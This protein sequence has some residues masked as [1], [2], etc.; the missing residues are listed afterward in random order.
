MITVRTGADPTYKPEWLFGTWHLSKQDIGAKVVYN[1]KTFLH[2]HA[3]QFKKKK[4]NVDT[5]R[6]HN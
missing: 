5:V 4:K 2:K 1:R 3:V 6:L